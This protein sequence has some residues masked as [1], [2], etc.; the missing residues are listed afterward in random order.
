MTRLVVTSRTEQT[1]PTGD[2][3]LYS[4][5][6]NDTFYVF[7]LTKTGRFYMFFMSFCLQKPGGFICPLCLSVYKN[8]EVLYV[9]YVFLSTKTERLYMSFMSFCLQNPGGFI[10]SLCLSV[11]KTREA[12][13]VLY[14]FLSTKTKRLYMSLMSFCLQKPRDS[15]CPLCLSV[16]KKAL[17]RCYSVFSSRASSARV[18]ARLAVCGRRD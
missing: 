3:A 12:L 1:H 14:V 10:C 9:P 5:G 6:D 8:R 15:I 11:Y 2:S 13:Y 17:F 18:S 4:A 16:Y 7:L